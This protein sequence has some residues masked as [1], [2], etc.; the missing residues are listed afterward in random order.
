MRFTLGAKPNANGNIYRC[1][2]D[3]DKKNYEV[4]FSVGTYTDL[5]ATSKKE[6]DDFIKYVLKNEGYRPIIRL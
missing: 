4:G 6:I 2:V 1:I 5:H 3:T